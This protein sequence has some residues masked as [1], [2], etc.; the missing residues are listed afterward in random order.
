MSMLTKSLKSAWRMCVSV[1][2]AGACKLTALA[3]RRGPSRTCQVPGLQK[4]VAEH[5]TQ[6][7]AGRFVEVGAYDGERFS[8]TSW[9]ADNGWRGVYIEPS[10][11]FSRLCRLRHCLNDVKV[12][13]VAAGE[14][15]SEA[16]LMQVGSLSTM[17]SETF[18]EYGR[19]PW[20][21]TQIQKN[22]QKKTTQIRPLH[23]LLTEIGC[24]PGFELLVVDV[25]GYEENV[26]R[27]FDLGQ[28]SPGMII[29]E[30]C[31]AHPDFADNTALIQSAARVRQKIVTAGYKE[32]YRD[33]INTVFRRMSATAEKSEVTR[34]LSRRAA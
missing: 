31:D 21:K 27:G 17:S 3:G 15:E 22:C 23:D 6:S 34:D 16:T 13:N 9:L 18:D 19:I 7:K 26:F 28:W 33:E 30:L 14:T 25:E 24:R 4:L 5:L 10:A 1:G 20:A 2:Y 29:V 8:N 32:V 11:E 12:L